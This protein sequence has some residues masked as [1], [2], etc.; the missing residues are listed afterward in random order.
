MFSAPFNNNRRSSEKV[1]YRET[2]GELARAK[3]DL[4]AQ[5]AIIP[6]LTQTESSPQKI[7]LARA[8]QDLFAQ[9]AIR[10][11]VFSEDRT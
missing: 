3:Q 5:D 1:R 9:D 7:E 11:R 2:E 10:D 8:K 6:E 4:F